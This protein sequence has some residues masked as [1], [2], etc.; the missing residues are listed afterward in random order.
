MLAL[1]RMYGF[2]REMVNTSS[3]RSI[4]AGSSPAGKSPMQ[5]LPNAFI[6]QVVV[7]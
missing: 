3:V 6:L 2:L 7:L 5:F 1:R 4:I